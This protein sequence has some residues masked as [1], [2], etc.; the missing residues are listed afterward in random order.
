M[1][2]HSAGKKN[3]IMKNSGTWLY[4]ERVILTEVTQIQK[5][6]NSI[7]SL[8]CVLYICLHLEQVLKKTERRLRKEKGG[9][10]K[11]GL[12]EGKGIYMT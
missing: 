2:F 10:E 12:G 11:C 9:A 8:I 6:K 4:R 7:F 5:D 1:E 3:G